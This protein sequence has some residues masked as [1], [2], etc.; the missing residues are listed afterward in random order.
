MDDFQE[1]D[2]LA[3]RFGTDKSSQKAGP[4]APKG[5]TRL[6]AKYFAHLRRRPPSILEIGIYGG[7]SLKLWEAFFPNARIFGLDIGEQC[8]VFETPRT[9]IF[10]GDQADRTFLRSVVQ[11]IGQPLDI[12]ID[13]GGHKMHQHRVSLEELFPHL[14]PSGLYV[15]E[16]LSTAYWPHFEGGFGKPQTT[17]EFL[18]RTVDN[19]N[20]ADYLKLHPSITPADPLPEPL[21]P[22]LARLES[23]HFYQA[24]VFLLAKG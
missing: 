9:R 6:Y 16:D 14:S 18:K 7:A 24:I 5:Y 19:L 10:I 12:V 4:L 22:F 23:I 8:R 11:Q 17:I 13:D 2:E 21:P 3:R 20:Y 15:I 1:L